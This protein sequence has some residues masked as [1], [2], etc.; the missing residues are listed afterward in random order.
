MTTMLAENV[1]EEGDEETRIQGTKIVIV[2]Q[3][4]IVT[5][6]TTAN[7]PVPQVEADLAGIHHEVVHPAHQEEQDDLQLGATLGEIRGVPE[8]GEA[9]KEAAEEETALHARKGNHLQENMT[10]LRATNG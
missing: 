7:R 1:K 6:E 10:D 5:H 8:E 2:L 4:N 9:V 3:G